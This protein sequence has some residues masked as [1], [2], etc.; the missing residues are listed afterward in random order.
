MIKWRVPFVPKVG[1]SPAPA[2]VHAAA[3]I[4]PIPAPSPPSVHATHPHS[5]TL[6]STITCNCSHLFIWVIV[7]C[8]LLLLFHAYWKQY[9]KLKSTK[10]IRNSRC[11]IR[12]PLSTL[13]IPGQNFPASTYARHGAWHLIIMIRPWHTQN[14]SH[15]TD[16]KADAYKDKVI[17]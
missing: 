11:R 6:D 2:L 13:T 15:F 8:L 14:Y 10:G 4:S 1:Q 16:E 5:W 12:Q 3:S 7:M 9:S 17:S